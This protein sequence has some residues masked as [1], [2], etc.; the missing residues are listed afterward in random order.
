[1][2]YTR[3]ELG[4]MA[5]VAIPAVQILGVPAVAGQAKPDSKVR[6]VTIGMNVPYNFGPGPNT[7]P[8][9][10]A[11]GSGRDAPVD[12][13]IQNCVTLGVSG[14]ELRTQP[15]ESFLGAPAQSLGA[16]GGQRG[17][18]AAPTPEQLAA[19]AATAAELQKWRLSAAMAPV[20]ALRKR[21]EDAGVLIEI[22]KV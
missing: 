3:R 12:E 19:S 2:S 6:G 18:G 5:L 20:R 9:G 17:R 7:P 4:R 14:V 15:V 22:V 13:I 10:A 8:R 1:M 21:F 16:G 11:W